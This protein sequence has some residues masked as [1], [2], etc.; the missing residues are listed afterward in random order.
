MS[1]LLGAVGLGAASGLNAWIPLLGLGVAQRLGAVT[2]TA[3]FDRLGSTAV[4]AVLAVLFLIDLIGDKIAVVDHVLHAL[5]AVVAPVS[6]AVVFAAQENLISQSHPWV[7]GA[8]G[9]VLAGGT[10]VAR[11]AARPAVTTGN[12]RRGQSRG[13]GV[14]GPRRSDADRARGR[15][16]RARGGAPG[17]RCGADRASGP[18]GPAPAGRTPPAPGVPDQRPPGWPRAVP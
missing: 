5:G 6:G 8:A 14:R 4:L 13:L 17:G 16:A 9:V 1:N 10:H 12:R 11:S 15:R 3:P 2:L 18:T 7:A